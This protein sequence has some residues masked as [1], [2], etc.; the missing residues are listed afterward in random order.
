MSIKTH[1]VIKHILA[2]PLRVGAIIALVV[3]LVALPVTQVS[4]DSF[5]EKIR[6]LQ[7]EVSKYQDEAGALRAQAASLQNELNALRAEMSAL[8]KQ[9][10]LKEAELEKI[11]DTIVKT[12]E[13]LE[14]QKKLLAGNL[15]AMYLEGQISPLEM[16]ASSKSIS[17]YIDKQEYRNKIR[18]QVQRNISDIR[19]LKEDLAKQKVDAERVLADQKG[20]KEVLAAKQSEQA[21]LLAQTQGQEAAYQ[22]LSREKNA[23]I[24]ALRAAQAALNRSAGG[25]L[26]PGDP[27]KGGYPAKWANAPLD[28]FLDNWGMYTRQCVSYAAYRVWASGRHMPYWGGPDG[29]GHGGNAKLWPNNA[30]DG[31][32]NGGVPIPTGTEPRV[33]AVAIDTR[34]T[35]GHAMYV[36]AVLPNNMI[37]VSQYNYGWAGEYSEMTRSASG[38]VYIYF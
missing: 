31:W 18:D 4:A 10:D 2:M 1:S 14:N 20:Q 27:N 13:R 9:I 25:K 30:R 23:E 21:N 17:D 26:V 37:Y 19:Q 28:A 22:R 29:M 6:A 38:L 35:Y 12:E 8:Q 33:G 15:R 16:V 32:R 36:E 24:A 5:D 3:S 11:K 34:G 7:Q